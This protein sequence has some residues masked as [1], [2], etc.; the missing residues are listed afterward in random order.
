MKIIAILSCRY[1][2]STIL[3]YMLGS[4]S[5]A[6]SLTE[7]RPFIIGGRKPFNCKSC[8]PSQSCPI[9][10]QEF[11]EK[12]LRIGPIS[13]IYNEISLKTGANVL[14]DSSK[15]V[16]WFRKT[17]AGVDP[18]DILFVHIS[19]SPEE[20]G[21]SERNKLHSPAIHLVTEIGDEWWRK[22]SAI[23]RFLYYSPYQALF[24]RYKDLIESPKATL[25]IILSYVGEKYE[26]GIENFWNF[27]HHPLW[28][29]KGARSHLTSTDSNP[30]NWVGE[31][32]DNK[33]LYEK[34]HQTLFYDEK[35]R[36]SFSYEEI[37]TLY[38]S[39]RLAEVAKLLGY[40]NPYV[41]N[42]ILSK[43][44]LKPQLIDSIN[45]L[46]YEFYRQIGDIKN[47]YL[48]NYIRTRGLRN[49]MSALFRKISI[50]KKKV[51]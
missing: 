46:K 12:L 41:Q 20:Y 43:Y 29:N 10:S 13:Q 40:E 38:A 23:L 17:L 11:T 49:G 34:K 35:W 44:S 15:D 22:N 33:K 1:S 19:K 4:H 25:E 50:S 6:L 30:S 8:Q 7:I 27:N 47:W 39:G 48:I 5:N 36:H 18:K 45:G 37:F 16:S 21:G 26:P 42:D 3:D 31:S 51:H 14:I 9:Y 32:D 24:I 2:G 28:G